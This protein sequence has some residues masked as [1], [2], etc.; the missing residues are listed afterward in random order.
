EVDGLAATARDERAKPRAVRVRDR[1]WS[2]NAPRRC[3]LVAGRE[4]ADPWPAVDGDGTDRRTGEERDLR[5][6]QGRASIEQAIA[7]MQVRSRAPD[8]GADGYRDVH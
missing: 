4:H 7:R 2:Q 3:Q 8:V 6:T 1:R 5:R